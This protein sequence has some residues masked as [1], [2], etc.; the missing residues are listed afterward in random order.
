MPNCQRMSVRAQLTKS[1]RTMRSRQLSSMATWQKAVRRK[2]AKERAA[3]VCSPITGAAAPAR[4]PIRKA[5]SAPAHKATNGL[6]RSRKA[7]SG[8]GHARNRS[9]ERAMAPN[10]SAET[11]SE[12]AGRIAE[13]GA[14]RVSIQLRAN[15]STS[16]QGSWATLSRDI[17]AFMLLLPSRA[18]IVVHRAFHEGRKRCLP[19][20]A[21]RR[22]CCEQEKHFISYVFSTLS[23]G[24]FN[25]SL[26]Q[27]DAVKALGWLS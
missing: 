21:K 22:Y 26:Q 24:C 25:R 1:R 12:E 20:A 6:R 9:A 19:S 4:C 3:A 14:G 15:A 18:S 10:P 16:P 13:D 17:M 8:C 5:T 23:R 2:T 7:E 11:P 27:E